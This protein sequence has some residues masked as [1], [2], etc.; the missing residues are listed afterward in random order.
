MWDV[1]TRRAVGTLDAGGTATC[2]PLATRRTASR[3]RSGF[4]DGTV[5]V[6]DALA[7]RSRVSCCT[8]RARASRIV[9]FSGDGRRIAAALDDGTVRVLAADAQ[10]AGR[11]VSTATTDRSLGVDMDADG[12]RVVSA[13][14][15]G[16]VRL[17]DVADGATTSPAQPAETRATTS[18]SAR[19]GAG[20]WPSA[21]TAG[22]GY[23]TL[24]PARTRTT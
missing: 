18:R 11:G 22:S 4:E 21:T 8:S 3:S 19:T 5:L 2:S 23:G 1:A 10:R 7:R 24:G 14:E 12:S 15:D 17:W 20:S 6:T 9:A 16:S 13:G